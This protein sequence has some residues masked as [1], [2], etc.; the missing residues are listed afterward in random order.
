MGI[1][2]WKTHYEFLYGHLDDNEYDFIAHFFP[3]SDDGTYYTDND[4]LNKAISEAQKK[5]TGVSDDLLETLR[6]AIN[7]NEGS[8]EF[9]IF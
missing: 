8:L 7:D 2:L 9:R 1:D 5:N 6:K 4:I 3:I